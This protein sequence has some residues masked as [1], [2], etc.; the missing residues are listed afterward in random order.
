MAHS[1]GDGKE[2]CPSLEEPSASTSDQGA[3]HI[4]EETLLRKW[5][6]LHFGLYGSVRAN[7]FARTKQ[8][9]KK[10]DWKDPT[11]RLTVYFDGG[12]FLVFYNCRLTWR[13]CPSV[14][15]SCD[16]LSP[17]FD[18]EKALS[19][20]SQARP[21]CLILMDQRHFSGVGNIIK[22]EIL[23]Q[24]RVHPLSLGSLLPVTTRTT[25]MENAVRFTAD[26]LSSM[27]RG[28][29]LHYHIYLKEQCAD[30]H[31][32]TKETI[33]P[34]RGLKRLTW[35]CPVCQKLAEPEE[36]DA[37]YPSLLVE[38]PP[39]PETAAATTSNQEK[40]NEANAQLVETLLQKIDRSVSNLE[41]LKRNMCDAIDSAQQEFGD[42]RA[43]IADFWNL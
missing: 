14:E 11:P 5:L 30:G 26:W 39:P 10:G 41:V 21:V 25:L 34:W 8:G 31:P 17:E 28:E 3:P 43:Q 4:G 6:H 18:K 9:N 23:Y 38:P 2:E 40:N 20:L 13:S 32:V 36:K 37:N 15:P 29:A 35:Y 24:A 27:M 22:N 1:M 42:L 33:G 16:V 19:A 7:E 12:G